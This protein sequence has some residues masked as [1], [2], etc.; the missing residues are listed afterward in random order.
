MLLLTMALPLGAQQSPADSWHLSGT[1]GLGLSQTTQTTLFPVAGSRLSSDYETASG[2]LGLTLNGFWKDPELLP[3]SLDF[4]GARGSNK[5][6]SGGYRDLLLNWGVNTTFLP[7]RSFP[8]RFFY[9]RS[10]LGASGDTFGQNADTSTFGVDWTLKTN[11]LPRITT[12]Y[13]RF[14]N[15][16]H[17]PTSLFDNN[18]RQGHAYAGMEDR[19]KGWEWGTGFDRYTNTSNFVTGSALPT[20]FQED[21]LAFGTHLRRAFGNSK[22][23][24][25]LDNRDQWRDDVLPGRGTSRSRNYYTEASL[26][27]QHTPK[28]SSSYFYDYVRLDFSGTATS[29]LIPGL[30]GNAVLLTPPAFDS[31]FAGGRLDYRLTGN[32]RFFEAVRYQHVTPVSNHFEFRESLSE[33]LSGIVYQKSWRGFDFRG[34][35]TG[36]FQWMGTNLGNRT[37]TFSNDVQAQA[38]WGSARRIR[39]V[40]SAAYSKLNLVDQLNGFSQDRRYRLDAETRAVPHFAFRFTADHSRI[41]LLNQAG[42]VIQTNTSL[43]VQADHKR[44]SA[45]YTRN[46]GD[47]AGALFPEIV[48]MNFVISNPLP[49]EQLSRSPLLN[50]AVYANSASLVLKLLRNLDLSG[51]WRTERNVLAASAF[52]FKI[53]EAR[54]RYRIGKITIDVGY[55]R[56]RN[57]SEIGL[58]SSGLHTNRYL[59]RVARDFRVF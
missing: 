39:L 24:F 4:H 25:R 44:F 2:D 58:N 6:G 8:L 57:E 20:D 32:L 37:H 10:Q 23:E 27:L 46:F 30:P 9:R 31:H 49:L 1:L 29:T 50:R 47:G 34:A 43:G 48:R 52:R 17:I 19:W 7:G 56:Y 11:R 15:D 51:N 13:T 54:A 3:F 35:Y 12:G 22:G 36:H 5:A 53:L 21:L 41:E 59:L 18:Y 42:D 45:S 14:A 26:R 55:G 28:L 33:S 16:I 38:G 40:A